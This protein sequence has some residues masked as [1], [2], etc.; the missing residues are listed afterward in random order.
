MKPE[1]P[2]QPEKPVIAANEACG[3]VKGGPGAYLAK[4]NQKVS[5]NI[6]LS[7]NINRNGHSSPAR[8]GRFGQMAAPPERISLKRRRV[9]ETV[10]YLRK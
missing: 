4:V 6:T 2:E 5:P 7:L 8:F 3:D 9:D 10:E 1:E